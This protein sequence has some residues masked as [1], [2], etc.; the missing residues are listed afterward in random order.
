ML[1]FRNISTLE[2]TNNILLNEG[3]SGGSTL[4]TQFIIPESNSWNINDNQYWAPAIGSPFDV[5]DVGTYS[6]SGWQELGYDEGSI[7]LNPDFANPAEGE[8]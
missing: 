1:D 7:E 8:F 2:M 4:I 5:S 3:I 6:F